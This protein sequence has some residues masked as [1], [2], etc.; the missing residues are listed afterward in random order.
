MCQ[1]RGYR[2]E[3]LWSEW[4]WR[5]ATAIPVPARTLVEFRQ[6][7]AGSRRIMVEKN[8]EGSTANSKSEHW[9]MG[10]IEGILYFPEIKR[11]K[12]NGRHSLHRYSHVIADSKCNFFLHRYLFILFYYEA[13][14]K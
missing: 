11:E 9:V 7:R 5:T 12:N 3:K 1:S 10:K 2:E 14:Y 8:G 6:C 13:R 4:Q